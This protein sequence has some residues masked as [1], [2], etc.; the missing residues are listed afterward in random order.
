ML[1]SLVKIANKLDSLGLTKEADIIDR[2]LIKKAD[3]SFS[4]GSGVSTSQVGTGSAKSSRDPGQILEVRNVGEVQAKLTS[5]QN[6]LNNPNDVIF[7][8]NKDQVAIKAYS[9]LALVLGQAIVE[10][11]IATQLSDVREAATDW[12]SWATKGNTTMTPDNRKIYDFL[13][14][15]AERLSAGQPVFNFQTSAQKPVAPTTPRPQDDKWKGYIAAD[16]KRAPIWDAWVKSRE[17][18]LSPLNESDLSFDNFIIWWKTNK[19]DRKFNDNNAGGISATI[20]KLK[21]ETNPS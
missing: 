7:G 3:T 18:I 21:E 2:Y 15:A 5:I 4:A 11:P 20:Q 16:N 13:T 9:S 12:I 19:A 14:A 8:I 1:R 17:S 6:A 10:T